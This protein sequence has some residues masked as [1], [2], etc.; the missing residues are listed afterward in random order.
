MPKITLIDPRVKQKALVFTPML[1]YFTEP[2]NAF[3]LYISE[4]D[5]RRKLR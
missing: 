4:L 3:Q 1:K 5:I 2:P